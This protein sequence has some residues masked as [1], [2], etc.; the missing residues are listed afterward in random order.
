MARY[1]TENFD[2]Q[3]TAGRTKSRKKNNGRQQP[4]EYRRRAARLRYEFVERIIASNYYY[5]YYYYLC[6]YNRINLTRTNYAR[7]RYCTPII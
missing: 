7:L 2:A 1:I 6:H 3:Q 5:Y 4:S